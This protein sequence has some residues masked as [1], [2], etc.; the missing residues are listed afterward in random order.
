MPWNETCVMEQRLRF[1]SDWLEKT[2]TMSDLCE[3]YAVSR[4]TG[5]K[6]IERY[7]VEGLDGLKERSHRPHGSPNRTNPQHVE[8]IIQTKLRYQSFGP[9]KV[10]DYL[11]RTEPEQRWPADSTAGVILKQAGLV[12]DKKRRRRVAAD[13]APFRHCTQANAVWSADFKGDFL[14]GNRQRCYP[15]TLSDNYSRYLLECR[16]LHRTGYLHVYPWFEWAFREYGLPDAIRIDNGP[17]FASL[18]LGGISQLSKWWIQLGIKPER[19]QPGKPQQ[20]G[21]HERMHKSLKAAVPIQ[22]SWAAQQ[23][24]FNRFREEFNQDRSHEALDRKTPAQLHRT[25]PRPYPLK[26]KPIEY[27][28]DYHVR[29]VRSNGEIKWKGQMVYLSH[30]LAQEPI[31]LKQIDEH[32]WQLYFGFYLLGTWDDTHHSIKPTTHWHQAD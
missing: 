12:Q 18:A 6:W 30:V 19:I 23:R 22:Y 1:I 2:Y 13:T 17:P 9:K 24:A 15:L 4:K 29:R 28:T 25:S 31:G 7:Q 8:R 21:R 32:Q 5:Y 20:N 11:R 16:G 27:T 14:L 10:M 3:H 26:L